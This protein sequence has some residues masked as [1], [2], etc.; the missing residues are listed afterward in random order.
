MTGVAEAEEGPA[1]S[2]VKFALAAGA[3]A[4]AVTLGV[5]AVPV[6]IE[7]IFLG[8]G[9][10]FA[11]DRAA[12]LTA[13][14]ACATAI[15]ALAEERAAYH[16]ERRRL[17]RGLSL[18]LPVALVATLIALA[19]ATWTSALFELGPEAAPSIAVRRL[20]EREPAQWWALALTSLLPSAVATTR[21]VRALSPRARVAIGGATLTIAY[22]AVLM[23]DRPGRADGAAL[24]ACFAGIVYFVGVSLGDRFVPEGRPTTSVPLHA[25]ALPFA[26]PLIM[27]NVLHNMMG[28]PGPLLAVAWI[29]Y[30][31]VSYKRAVLRALPAELDPG[32]GALPPWFAEST[33]AALEAD[34]ARHGMKRVALRSRGD[35]TVQ[36]FAMGL[37]PTVA[38]IVQQATDPKAPAAPTV[39][40]VTACKDLHV[41]T[42]GLSFNALT[43]FARSPRVSQDFRPGATVDELIARHWLD[44]AALAS[45]AGPPTGP[46]S[47]ESYLADEAAH[48]PPFVAK[49]RAVPAVWLLF[50]AW[51]FNAPRPVRLR[52]PLPV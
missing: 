4:G 45:L 26:L 39:L 28:A 23:S 47:V 42:S 35:S 33:F 7:A 11:A 10:M 6:L 52:G 9:R 27:A 30:Q 49:V 15:L 44:V 21:A 29:I 24:Q 38:M 25:I 43:W 3:G 14:V 51:W 36:A 32:G 17:G 34:L 2:T 40:F 12:G 5:M 46:G 22:G 48:W 37:G 19:H 1:R 50:V 41:A 8:G 18:I 20:L 13:A 31:A 16:V